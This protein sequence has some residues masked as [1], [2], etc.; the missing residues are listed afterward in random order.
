MSPISVKKITNLEQ[1]DLLT[2]SENNHPEKGIKTPELGE[3]LP[4]PE[5]RSEVKPKEKE[6]FTP[7]KVSLP[8]KSISRQ[9]S[10]S[11]LKPA[12]SQTLIQI[13][14]IMEH[15]LSDI[16]SKMEG[17]IQRRFKTRGEKTA[18]KI[19][20]ILGKTQ[21]ITQN[22]T[23]KVFKLILKWLNAIPGVNKFFI[24]QE[25]II[26]TEKIINLKNKER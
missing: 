3:F 5:K 15:D 21:N 1:E 18:M 8:E 22:I 12:K 13:E 14:K 2:S 6:P 26:K 9:I 11:G 16:Y 19:E 17:K 24:K 4:L 25:A 20:R 10:P 23:K 7:E